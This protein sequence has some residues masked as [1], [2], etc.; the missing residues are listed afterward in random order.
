MFALVLVNSHLFSGHG[1]F[2]SACERTCEIVEDITGL[3]LPLLDVPD[4]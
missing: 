1:Y 3:G 2:T 4:H